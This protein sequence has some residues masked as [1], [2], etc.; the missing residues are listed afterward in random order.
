MTSVALRA[1]ALACHAAAL[2][3]VEP[4]RLIAECL[5]RDGRGLV[6]RD[7][8]GRMLARHEGPVLLVGAGK[9]SAGMAGAVADA[10]RGG[11]VIVPHGSAGRSAGS[12]E[13]ATATI[14]A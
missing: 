3:A 8:Q 7:R 13:M 5:A 12:V 9:A 10:T 6:L 2:A 1:D 14:A 4:R 11:L